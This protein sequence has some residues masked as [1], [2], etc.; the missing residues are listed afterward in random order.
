MLVYTSE[1]CDLF[2][3]HLHTLSVLLDTWAVRCQEIIK[4]G[5][6]TIG[7]LYAQCSSCAFLEYN[8]TS[9]ESV[10]PLLAHLVTAQ[11]PIHIV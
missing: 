6:T 3:Q 8:L 1:T 10:P 4:C 9:K 11:G 7:V 2:F 5:A